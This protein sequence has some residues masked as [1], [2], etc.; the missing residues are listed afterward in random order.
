VLALHA[1]GTVFKVAAIVSFRSRAEAM[2]KI[3]MHDRRISE[4]DALIEENAE[5]LDQ[6]RKDLSQQYM[7]FM[8][9]L[10]KERL[11]LQEGDGSSVFKHLDSGA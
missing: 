9:R 6:V 4:A 7:R 1:I 11:A 3:A 10:V 5:I 8:S 2:D